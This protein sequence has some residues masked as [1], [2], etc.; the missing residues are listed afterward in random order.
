MNWLTNY[1]EKINSG[2][3]NFGQS[4]KKETAFPTLHPKMAFKILPSILY[5]I[6]IYGLTSPIL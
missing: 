4:D 5:L 2:E 1:F 3:T 6:L